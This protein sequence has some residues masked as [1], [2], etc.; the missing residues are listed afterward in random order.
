MQSTNQPSA[1]KK[2][3]R[4]S[5]KPWA[6]PHQGKL[7]WNCP[8]RS[9]CW[10]RVKVLCKMNLHL[11]GNKWQMAPF[12][13]AWTWGLLSLQCLRLAEEVT[14]SSGQD[15][16]HLGNTFHQPIQPFHLYLWPK[17]CSP[18]NFEEFASLV[19]WLGFSHTALGQGELLGMVLD[20]QDPQHKN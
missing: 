3:S 20:K 18:S 1:L 15:C 6:S 12:V 9:A 4:N 10:D 5:H 11:F 13:N 14:S 7:P 17:T 8:L 2:W 19:P 16:L